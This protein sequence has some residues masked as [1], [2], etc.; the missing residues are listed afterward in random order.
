MTIAKSP[1]PKT[2]H[3]ILIPPSPS[4]Q[5]LN[6][7]KSDLIPAIILAILSPRAR[8]VSLGRRA[9]LLG[10]TLRVR[11]G[12][13]ADDARVLGILL[14]RALARVGAACA[15]NVLQVLADGGVARV[16]GRVLLR[17]AAGLVL[18]AARLPPEDAAEAAGDAERDGAGAEEV[19]CGCHFCVMCDV[20]V[21]GG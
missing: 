13:M 18:A 11:R 19:G 12:R 16:V 7:V 5:F 14:E 2:P 9:R 6:R 21:C 20:V 17:H 15:A 10:V 1:R 8:R 3:P 4:P